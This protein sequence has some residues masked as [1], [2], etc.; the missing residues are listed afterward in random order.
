M[1]PD[2]LARKLTVAIGTE[3]KHN[4]D[5]SLTYE[6]DF[7]T[8]L[9]M[10]TLQEVTVCVQRWCDNLM[11]ALTKE[12]RQRAC[13]SLPL[14]KISLRPNGQSIR[15]VVDSDIRPLWDAIFSLPEIEQLD[16]TVGDGFLDFDTMYESWLETVPLSTTFGQGYRV[17]GKVN[18]PMGRALRRSRPPTRYARAGHHGIDHA[19]GGGRVRGLKR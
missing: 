4:V 2:L 3:H 15:L 7:G 17:G 6:E 19:R 8:L 11:K 14:R 9:K 18:D 5:H 13:L 12:F 10:P 16:L 1:H